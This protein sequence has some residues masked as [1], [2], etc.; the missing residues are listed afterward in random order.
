MPMKRE[1]PKVRVYILA[2]HNLE[3]TFI[4][5]PDQSDNTKM[6]RITKILEIFPENGPDRRHVQIF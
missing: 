5:S 1:R 6:K 3:K 2:N 4:W